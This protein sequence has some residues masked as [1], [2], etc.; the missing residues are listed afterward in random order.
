ME[1]DDHICLGG[2]QRPGGDDLLFLEVD[3]GRRQFLT[4]KEKGYHLPNGVLHI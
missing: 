1:V 2:G 4:S 3:V